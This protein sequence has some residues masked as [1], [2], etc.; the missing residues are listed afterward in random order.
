LRA[1]FSGISSATT[2]EP[3]HLPVT[4]S[5]EPSALPVS[6][7][8]GH[9]AVD[10]QR[11]QH[12]GQLEHP[13]H[14]RS[15]GGDPKLGPVPGGFP[16]RREQR[17]HAC[18]ITEQGAGHIRDE[19]R[20]ARAGRRAQLLGNERSVAQVDLGRQPDQSGAASE[21][22]RPSC[23]LLLLAFLGHG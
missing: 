10:S 21:R 2:A 1:G 15:P 7:R 23:G 16:A 5:Q 9:A 18:A 20:D 11:V 13:Q 8:A 22:A 19:N 14:R 12:A 17:A 4:L 6:G 3:P